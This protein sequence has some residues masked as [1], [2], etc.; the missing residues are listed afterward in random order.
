MAPL[1]ATP[2]GPHGPLRVKGSALEAAGQFTLLPGLYK[3]TSFEVWGEAVK[4]KTWWRTEPGAGPARMSLPGSCR[5]TEP[6]GFLVTHRPVGSPHTFHS[7]Q[8]G[9]SWLPL[10][11]CVY[12]C[13]KSLRKECFFAREMVRLQLLARAG[14]PLTTRLPG[15]APVGVAG[16]RPGSWEALVSL[17]GP[18]AVSV[19]PCPPHRGRTA[20]TDPAS[21]SDQSSSAQTT[22]GL[23][24]GKFWF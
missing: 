16:W 3:N 8:P 23:R 9:R 6:P 17:L 24:A 19:A 11:V 7:S 20:A 13:L 10:C 4:G 14:I 18:Q 15:A 12:L 2:A 22:R 21:D 5:G 1:P